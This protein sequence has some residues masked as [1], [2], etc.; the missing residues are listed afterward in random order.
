[1]IFGTANGLSALG[2]LSRNFLYLVVDRLVVAR[3]RPDDAPDPQGIDAA[4]IEPRVLD[5]VDGRAHGEL[6]CPPHAAGELLRDVRERVE[7]MDL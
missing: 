1:M 7:M 2:P 4:E 3:G 6:G 5:G